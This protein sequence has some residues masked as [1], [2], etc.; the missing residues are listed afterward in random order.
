MTND[1]ILKQFGYTATP[2]AIEQLE[3]VKNNTS[4]FDYVEK[5][6]IAL[7][8][9]LQSQLSYVALSS[10]K[11]YFKIKNEALEPSIKKAVESA[12]LQWS[13]KYKIDIEKVPNKET[14]YVLG[15]KKEELNK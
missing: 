12:I 9:Q 1:A 5:H 13:K 10:S 14:Y 3:K 2:N 8:D 4:G 15:F 6:L 11:D 7:H